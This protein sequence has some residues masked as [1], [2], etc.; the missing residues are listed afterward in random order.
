[1]RTAALAVVLGAWLLACDGGG[2]GALFGP[3]TSVIP[4]IVAPG[5]VPPT[6]PWPTRARSPFLVLDGAW[7]FAPD[8]GDAGVAAGWAEGNGDAAPFDA[9]IRVP[10]PPESAGAFSD[11]V[12]L[13]SDAVRVAWYRTRFQVGGD[14]GD[15]RTFL[16]FLGVQGHADVWLN[17]RPVGQHDGGYAPFELEVSDALAEGENALVVR[18]AR[19]DGGDD[20]LVGLQ[21][22]LGT[23]SGI[24]R[25]VY[26]ELRG[27]RW[28]GPI[29]ATVDDTGAHLT[30]RATLEGDPAAADGYEVAVVDGDGAVTAARG[31]LPEAGPWST[32][33]TPSRWT[34]W[35]PAEPALGRGALRLTRDGVVIDEQRF[36]FGTRDVQ[37]AW[38]PGG[39]PG[40]RAGEDAPAPYGCVHVNG[41]ATYLR[42]VTVYA[43]EPWHRGACPDGTCDADLGAV[44]ALGFDAVRVRGTTLPPRA[45]AEADRRGLMVLADVP[46][47]AE[48]AASPLV[49]GGA[50]AYERQLDALLPAWTL[51]PSVV[52]W[53]LF[54]GEAGLLHPPFWRDGAL[55]DWL[56]GLV[57]R[58]RGLARRALIED[59]VAGGFSLLLDGSQPH[60]TTDVQ[61]YLAPASTLAE[62]GTWLDDLGAHAVPGSW[63]SFV[64]ATPA[65]GQPIVVADA[66]CRTGSTAG[67]PIAGCLP[68]LLTRLRAQYRLAGFSLAALRD[69]PGGAV[70]LLDA[71]GEPKVWGYDAW[72]FDLPA[73][74]GDD[75]V[76]LE[77]PLLRGE[78][79]STP[80]TLAVG[81]ATG[82]PGAR[83]GQ[84]LRVETFFDTC[85][86]TG[87]PLREAVLTR[88]LPLPEALAFGPNAVGTLDVVSPTEPGVLTVLAR[89]ITADGVTRAAN[90]LHVVVPGAC[91]RTPTDEPA[92]DVVV[93]LGTTW[94]GTW[95]AG[96]GSTQGGTMAGYGSGYFRWNLYPDVPFE[97]ADFERFALVF[98]AAP[99]PA[100]RPLP[101]T[102]G[103]VLHGRGWC[104]LNGSAAKTWFTLADTYADSRGVLSGL[105][106]PDLDW[107]W[108]DLIRLDIP[109]ERAGSGG[110]Y[111]VTV[112]CGVDP[113][114]EWGHGLRIF[115]ETAGRWPLKPAL[116]AWKKAR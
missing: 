55:T 66:T 102:D 86:V 59:N 29:E 11:G 26:A 41:R 37:P 61:S 20:A 92:P 17:G 30:L 93:P 15:H 24:W 91:Q 73:L 108:G 105:N 76:L 44:A 14:R 2:E 106:A 72:G 50:A 8:P 85:T 28:S 45:L 104:R 97:L 89:L 34:A 23:I 99:M 64:G 48:H 49:T 63:W 107:A 33:L 70:G 3:D 116:L 77:P 38:C 83:D 5:E 103:Q 95:S 69:A 31:A 82:S 57:A 1:M 98:E 27:R 22:T 101:Q 32:T 67:A 58:A 84:V 60:L 65:A 75:F 68:E 80:L 51:N 25:S 81:L 13:P 42:A 114:L 112:D 12:A 115:D 96:W 71:D 43:D 62:I 87:R 9:R 19:G 7:D 46:G 4:E 6:H 88:D 10:F 47:F 111:Y 74:L 39:A 18:T 54:Q 100:G 35:S 56:V 113:D 109:A 36:A 40:D 16:V 53:S 110:G 52:S 90:R 78:A 79:P 21:P 94:D